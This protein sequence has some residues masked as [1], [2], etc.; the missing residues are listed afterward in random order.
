MRTV[1]DMMSS[2]ERVLAAI[3]RKLP[4]R[5]PADYK[6]EPEVN[7]KLMKRFGTGDYET[8]LR[9]LE[10]DVRRIEPR[11]QGPPDKNLPGG[12]REDY[13]G[14]RA[15]TMRSQVAS[16]DMFVQTELW[17]ASSLAEL[18]R[19]PWP[20]PD[21]FDYSVMAAQAACFPERAVLYEGSD[22]FTRP[23]ILR[24]MENF[25]LDMAERPEMA[26]YLI[27]KF[28]DFYAEDLSRALEATRGGFQ[29]YC[30]W[31]DYGTQGG[32]LISPGMWR[33]FAGPYL[34]RLVDLCHSAGVAFMLHSCGAV[35]ELI[36]EFISIG[37]DVLDPIQTMAAGMEPAALKRD[38][39]E[40]I[41]FHGGLDTQSTLPFGGPEEV[42]TEVRQRTATLGRDG[43]YIIAP[44][45]NI[46]PD[47]PEENILAM[48]EPELRAAG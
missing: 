27:G 23:A 5:T 38:F 25:L 21:L 13:W 2:R 11:Y 29:L 18:E 48:Y 26:H 7:R 9:R 8:V 37:V 32:L 31:S 33:E 22:L 40:R 15:K 1:A 3:G 6:A 19:H 28:T 45:H 35:R 10:V 44:S 4:D 42:R 34:K 46:Q 20:S 17:A 16:Y 36:P 14:I 47:T 41:A 39:G 43:G 12:I 30:E 24:G